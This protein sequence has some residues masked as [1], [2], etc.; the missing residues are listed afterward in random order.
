MK[1]R[2]WF[3]GALLLLAVTL[4][5]QEGKKSVIPL[6]GSDAPAFTAE[7]TNG[8]L[9]FPGDFGKKW[10]ILFS[11]PQD[12]TPVCTTEILELARLQEEFKALGVEVAVISTDTKERHL[13]WKKSMEEVLSL[14]QPQ[15][16]IGFPL[17]DDS[18]V[19][20][21]RLYGML[22]EPASTTRDVR[23]CSSSIRPTRWKRHSSIPMPLAGI[24][25]KFSE[26]SRPCRPLSPPGS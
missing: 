17:I 16:R 25:M 12:F 22:H 21:S 6:I 15:L 26:Q 14:E 2:N 23:G 11:H 8:V 24:C 4:S 18:K 10:K 9:S 19:A 1:T 13:M 7:T 20:V 5:A 3:T